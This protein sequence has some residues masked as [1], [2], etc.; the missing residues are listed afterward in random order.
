MRKHRRDI[1][2][3]GTG[4]MA[5]IAFL[6][7]IFFLISSTMDTDSGIIRRLPQYTNNPDE[8]HL[9]RKER[10]VLVIL[11]NRNNKLMV[12]GKEMKFAELK[13]RAKEFIQNPKNDPN[14]P[15]RTLINV[16]DYG[17]AWIT[18]K[19]IISLRS[20]RGTSYKTYITV[21]NELAKA[22]NELRNEAALK[23]W[24]KEY[25]DLDEAQKKAVEKIYHL[26]ISE[27]EPNQISEQ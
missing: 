22:Y 8:G 18:D 25:P 1:Q 4:A 26:S 27:A 20:D 5:D 3:I 21:Q 13:D 15:E 17:P 14:L 16:S 6:L 7:L 9:E 19:H 24:K 2:T 11:V 12:R 23:K 10:N